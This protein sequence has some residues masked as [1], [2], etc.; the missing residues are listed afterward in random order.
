MLA[1]FTRSAGA[2]LDPRNIRP[3]AVEREV[4]GILCLRRKHAELQLGKTF[5]FGHPERIAVLARK[6]Q[7]VSFPFQVPSAV[8]AEGG[9]EL[10]PPIRFAS[11]HC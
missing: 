9:N 5:S 7:G 11:L 4:N 3:D 8:G 6:G 10:D 2:E 1:V